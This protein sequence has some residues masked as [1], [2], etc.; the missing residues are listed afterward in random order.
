MGAVPGGLF[1]LVEF[2]GRDNW[3]IG[4]SWTQRERLLASVTFAVLQL[5]CPIALRL[6]TMAFI[7]SKAAFKARKMASRLDGDKHN[8]R[9]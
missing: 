5:R 6:P 4:S 2:A 8:S 3:Q 9:R 1:Y 7:D